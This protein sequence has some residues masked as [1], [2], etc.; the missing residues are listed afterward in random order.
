MYMWLT[1]K[2]VLQFI[3]P[4][5]A[6]EALVATATSA[7]FRAPVV[8]KHET[9]I[10]L[11]F[12]NNTVRAAVHLTKFHHHHQSRTLLGSTL[13]AFMMRHPTAL[14]I[15]IPLSPKRYRERGYNQ[16]VEIIKAAQTYNRAI[17]YNDKLLRRTRHTA[18]QTTLHKKDRQTNI[19]SAFG[20]NQNAVPKNI[21]ELHLILLD[22]V[23]T[24]GSTLKAARATLLSLRPASITCVAIAG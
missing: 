11:P 16:V 23:V 13:A 22:D 14:L 4:P 8:R 12:K 19:R 7:S 17:T 15:P 20:I 3:F 24:T 2:Q 6:D 21:H 1:Y 9:S 5:S 10:L 18:P